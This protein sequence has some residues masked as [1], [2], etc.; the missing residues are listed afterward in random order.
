MR[1]VTQTTKVATAVCKLTGRG[2]MK[3]NDKMKDGRRSL[4][5]WGWTDEDYKN[6]ERILTAMGCKV[7]T[8]TVNSYNFRVT[9][10]KKWKFSQ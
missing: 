1:K 7:E 10:C 8:V 3:F 9:F 2:W 4:K 5:V 6:A